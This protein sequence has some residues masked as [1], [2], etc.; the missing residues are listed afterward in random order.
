MTVLSVTVCFLNV[1]HPYDCVK[2]YCLFYVCPIHMAVLSVTVCFLSVSHPYGC[3]K[4]Y[5]LFFKCVPS[6]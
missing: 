1:S 2:C 3:V 5:C 6:I 4:C